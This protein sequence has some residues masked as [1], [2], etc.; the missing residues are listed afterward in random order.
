MLMQVKRN[1]KS[2]GFCGPAALS[3]LTGEHVDDCVAAV[4]EIRKARRPNKRVCIRG[5]HNLEMLRVL[6]NLGFQYNPLHA[7]PDYPVRPRS[8][9]AG[10]APTLAQFLRWKR[11]RTPSQRFL[12]CTRNHYLVLRGN[13]IYDNN[14]PTGV[15]IRQYNHRRKRITAVWEVGVNILNAYPDRFF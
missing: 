5:M 3:L 4:R 13:K 15:F 14:N 6:R 9:H 1:A 11:D 12:L 2:N 7:R 8:K 10:N